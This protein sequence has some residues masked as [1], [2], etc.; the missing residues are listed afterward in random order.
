MHAPIMVREEGSETAIT[1]MHYNALSEI[2]LFILLYN[3][4]FLML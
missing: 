1:S 4:L 2:S 3:L